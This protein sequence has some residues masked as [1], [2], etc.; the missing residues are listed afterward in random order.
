MHSHL[1]FLPLANTAITAGLGGGDE[2][3]SAL[4]EQRNTEREFWLYVI[5][6]DIRGGDEDHDGFDE[7]GVSL[8]S[9]LGWVHPYL[10]DHLS[11]GGTFAWL[12]GDRIHC[13][14]HILYSRWLNFHD[15]VHHVLVSLLYLWNI[16]K[17][18]KSFFS[19]YLKFK[20]RKK[21]TRKV[22]YQTELLGCAGVASRKSL[23]KVEL[24]RRRK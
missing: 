17:R 2:L 23:G 6:L 11:H 5:H 4:N 22:Y 19:S 8:V 10:S 20:C 12:H 3:W 7:S 1:F 14:L 15:L 13:Y 24:S 9:A 18:W 16:P 21:P